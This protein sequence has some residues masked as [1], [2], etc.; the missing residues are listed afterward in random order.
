MDNF[1]TCC[2]FCNSKKLD[3]NPL[4]LP[5]VQFSDCRL[6]SPKEWRLELIER[7]K[8]HLEQKQWD[9]FRNDYREMMGEIA[10]TRAS[11]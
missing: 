3:T 10:A 9:Y 8:R 1:V 11:K 4:D 6:A 7:V 5:S 2:S